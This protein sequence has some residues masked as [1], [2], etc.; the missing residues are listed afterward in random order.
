[1]LR[2]LR[3]LKLTPLDFYSNFFMTRCKSKFHIP[4]LWI[5]TSFIPGIFYWD[6]HGGLQIFSRKAQCDCQRKDTWFL[7]LLLKK[8]I[9]VCFLRQLYDNS[10]LLQ[11]AV[12]EHCILKR[13]RNT[14]KLLNVNVKNCLIQIPDDEGGVTVVRF[15]IF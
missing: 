3:F 9:N 8:K 4:P 1:M 12:I 14:R 6:Q 15:N 7:L 5:P 10:L 2:I 11:L 13:R